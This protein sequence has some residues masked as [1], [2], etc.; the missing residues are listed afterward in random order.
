L[1]MFMPAASTPDI[2][3]RRPGGLR[4]SVNENPWRVGEEFRL[5]RIRAHLR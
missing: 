2:V 1:L 4:S 5:H 3:G